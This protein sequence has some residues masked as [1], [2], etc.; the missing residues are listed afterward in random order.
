ME[1]GKGE[2]NYDRL[3]ELDDQLRE[4]QLKLMRLLKKLGAT[5][6]QTSEGM[7]LVE[8]IIDLEH[9]MDTIRK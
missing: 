9:E 5:E 4:T 8:T 1:G 3:D 2:M 7:H 6:E